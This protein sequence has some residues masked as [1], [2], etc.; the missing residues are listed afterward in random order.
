VKVRS[1]I[2]HSI[3]VASSGEKHLWEFEGGLVRKLEELHRLYAGNIQIISGL[4][5]PMPT[6]EPSVED[7]LRWLS[8]EISGLLDMFSGV[9]ENFATTAI[10]GALVMPSDSIDL[11]VVRGTTAEGGVDVLPVGS[12]VRSV[13]WA[14]SK[15]WW[16]PFGYNYVLS[17]I[18]AKQE[19]VLVYF[20]V[21]L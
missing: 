8:N 16:R 15:K 11:D 3:D 18:H 10:E 9:N 14:V 4:C 13:T 1:V 2:A 12:N 20:D 19:E 17:V 21:L 7:Y 5:S 6:E